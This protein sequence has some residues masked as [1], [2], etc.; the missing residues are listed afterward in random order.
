MPIPV[1]APARSPAPLA[2]KSFARLFLLAILL[3]ILLATSGWAQRADRGRVRLPLHTA[4]RFVVDA[5]GRRVKLASV[6]WY[7]AE[8]KDFVVG[9]LD[10]QDLHVIA[11][12]IAALGFNSVRLPW[13]NQM[14]ESDP[15]VP[16]Y[17]LRANPQ[18]AGQHALAVF[19]ATVQALAASGLLVILD[20]HMSD[21]DWCC[22]RDDENGFWY[23]ARYPEARWI[24][25]WQQMAR[26]YAGQPAVVGADLR[27]EPRDPA[28]W[29]GSDP[30]LDWHAAAE[31]GGNAVLQANP[32][33]LIMVEGVHYASDLSGVAALPVHLAVPN[34]VVYS[35]HTYGFQL[36]KNALAGRAWERHI[37]PSWGYLVTGA[38]P[39]PI[40]IG[41]FGTCNTGPEC[42]ADG[43]RQ[44]TGSWFHTLMGYMRRN[45]VDWCYWALNGTQ[46]T[47]TG[48]HFGAVENYGILTRAWS[49]TQLPGMMTALHAAMSPSA[50]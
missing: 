20:N 50:P 47:G 13:S 26:R 34:H 5:A 39:Q 7:G 29:G 45:D 15:L 23:N 21:A 30:R 9:G 1:Q 33:L 25:D 12:H 35:P 42:L 40:W 36:P 10:R 24:A 38:Q 19:D 22:N 16:A 18:L 14:L 3:A 2:T 43:P 11:R 48:R 6:N 4:G 46:T 17:A 27:N 37:T 49:G 32:N 31:R 8:G 41:E 28:V 44:V